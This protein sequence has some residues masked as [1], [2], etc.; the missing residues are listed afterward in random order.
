[1]YGFIEAVRTFGAWKGSRDAPKLVL[2]VGWQVI[3]NLT[4]QQI[5]V[6][7]LLTAKRTRFWVL[8]YDDI[9]SEPLRRVLYYPT[10]ETKLQTVLDDVGVPAHKEW[11]LSLCPSPRHNHAVP[12]ADRS[13]EHLAQKALQ[14]IGVVFGSVVTLERAG[15]AACGAA[16]G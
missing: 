3:L 2:H 6:A 10:S 4:S 13:T 5:D 7:E 12:T 16:A 8:V 9:K 14:Q 11:L 15:S 1:V